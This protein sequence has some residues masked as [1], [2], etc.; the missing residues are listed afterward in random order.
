MPQLPSS[1]IRLAVGVLA[2]SL[3]LAPLAQA[4]PARKQ[5]RVFGGLVATAGAEYERLDAVNGGIRIEREARV[6]TAETV[7]GGI[8]VED[9]AEVGH[10]ETV[11]GGIRFGERIRLGH[12]ETVNG[13]IKL[14]RDSQASGS[15]R[16][17]NGGIGLA[18]GSRVEGD[19]ATINGG[20]RL[21]GAAVRGVLRT[22]NG[23]IHLE[24][25]SSAGG[26]QIEAVHRG[27]WNWSGEKLPRVV[28]G[29]DGVVDGPMVFR[30]TVRLYVHASAR[31]GPIE[32]ATPLP[33]EGESP[34]E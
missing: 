17:V 28:I 7:N 25:G 18:A 14:G 24:R 6:G 29:P 15:L 27:W 21:R 26:I 4:E 23:D 11:N 33:F 34:P 2:A 19:V 13:S 12:A 31:I 1:F 22:V 30:R 10:A 8:L 3:L 9:G 20:I 16:T 32:G 5:P